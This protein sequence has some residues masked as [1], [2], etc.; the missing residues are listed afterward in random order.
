VAAPRRKACNTTALPP[1][2]A[3]NHPSMR[4][5]PPRLFAIAC[6]TS[7]LRFARTLGSGECLWLFPRLAYRVYGS[8]GASEHILF[9]HGLRG[10]PGPWNCS[11][12]RLRMLPEVNDN[13][14][15][16]TYLPCSLCVPVPRWIWT[17]SC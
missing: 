4:L 14:P 10:S 8:L 3:R 2:T 12:P 5:P 9:P 11:W 6:Q 13:H 1:Y 15:P 7:S 16:S 17:F